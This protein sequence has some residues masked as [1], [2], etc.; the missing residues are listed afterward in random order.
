MENNEL[1]S[2]NA[3]KRPSYNPKAHSP[4]VYIP[5]W[6]IQVPSDKLSYAA[7]M[8]YGRLAQWSS[9]KGTVHRSVNQLSEELGMHPRGVERT[10]KELRDVKLICTYRIDHGGVNH[11][12]FL[13]HEWMHVQINDN[14]EYKNSST[15]PDKSVGTPPT[16]LSVPPD[17]SVGAKIKEIKVNKKSFSASRSVEHEKIKRQQSPNPMAD[18]TKQSTSYDPK[19]ESRQPCGSPLLEAYVKTHELS[20]VRKKT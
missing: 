2:S 20:V 5:C 11:Y 15:P 14:L 9:S 8:L 1:N 16:N 19:K 4:A 3:T 18:I 6:L 13:E 10:L 7:K 12:Q 17:K